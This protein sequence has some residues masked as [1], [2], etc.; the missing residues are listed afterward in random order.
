MWY[1]EVMDG[2]EYLNQISAAN[3]PASKA[4]GNKGGILSSKF[5]LVGI[6]GLAALVVVIVIGALLGGGKGGEKN[7]GTALILHLDSTKEVAQEYQN[8]VKSSELR[9]Y[10]ATLTGVLSNT[11]SDLTKY[12]EEK[13]D[14]KANKADKKLVEAA[15]TAKDEL[16]SELFEAKINGILDRIFAHKMAY[17]ISLITAE[18]TKLDKATKSDFVKEALSTSMSSLET[19]YDNF[20]NFSEGGK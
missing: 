5:V 8:S 12:M 6:I 14:F 2:Q 9:S 10:C 20:N 1:N 19:L 16:N 17:E 13:Y 4:G 7:I 11:S 18:E 15:N 3:R